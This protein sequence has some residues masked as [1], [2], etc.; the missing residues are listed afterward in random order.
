MLLC[1]PKVEGWRI[2]GLGRWVSLASE[3]AGALTRTNS[4][5]ARQESPGLIHRASPYQPHRDTC[6]SPPLFLLAPP[7]SFLSHP[8]TLTLLTRPRPP[9]ASFTLPFCVQSY[10]PV[11]AFLPFH[12]FASLSLSL[13]L[14]F[15]LFPCLFSC[16][17]LPSPPTFF[18]F[19]LVEK[20]ERIRSRFF[21][22][23]TRA[24]ETPLAAVLSGFGR[25]LPFERE[26]FSSATSGG[27]QTADSIQTP[28]SPRLNSCFEREP[29]SKGIEPIQRS[30]V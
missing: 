30:C 15:F 14:S 8:R 11:N 3:L 7:S 9:R 5:A 17:P 28:A 27:R 26:G 29:V 1:W 2:E 20:R 6:R 23:S 13:S 10:T 4:H 12:P 16:F 19:S 25:F 24:R 18:F 22:R 21:E